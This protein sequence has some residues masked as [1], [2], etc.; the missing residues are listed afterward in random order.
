MR[1]VI[2]HSLSEE[3]FP[4]SLKQQSTLHSCRL[5]STVG[6]VDLCKTTKKL[7]CIIGLKCCLPLAKPYPTVS[8]LTSI[9][10]HFI[11][12]T[13]LQARG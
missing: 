8:L 7:F 12:L 5:T 11:L 4:L 6:L 10:R 3:K 13:C 2:L 9:S 1:T